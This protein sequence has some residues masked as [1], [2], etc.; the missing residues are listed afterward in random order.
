MF[1]DVGKY[2]PKIFVL[3][4]DTVDEWQRRNQSFPSYPF[5]SAMA[6]K[7]FRHRDVLGIL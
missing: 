3:I 5:I 7:T 6:A 1:K 4:T 2:I